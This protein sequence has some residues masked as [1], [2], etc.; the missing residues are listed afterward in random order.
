MRVIIDTNVLLSGVYRGGKPRRVV[1]YAVETPHVF[2]HLSDEILA[3]YNDVLSR[4]KFNILP[5]TIAHWMDTIKRVATITSNIPPLD[6]PRD[7]KDAKFLALAR[8]TSADYLITGDTDF[9]DVPADLLP[10]T[11]ILSASEF[12]AE[13]HL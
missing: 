3:E 8:V 10:H 12:C 7:R 11:R 5:E 1:L 2:I 9:T 4:P 6:F 13:M